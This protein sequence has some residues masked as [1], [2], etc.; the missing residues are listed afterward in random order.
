MFKRNVHKYAAV[1][2]HIA[3]PVRFFRKSVRGRLDNR[4]FA[5]VF[6]HFGKVMMNYRSFGRRLMFRICLR[7]SAER[8]F[9][10]RNKTRF[11]SGKPQKLPN[12]GHGRAFA[13][14]SRN[15]DDRK[16]FRGIIVEC[17]TDRRH[18]KPRV[19]DF[20]KCRKTEKSVLRV[21]SA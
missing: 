5:A 6:D 9:H 3:E 16:F 19:F 11:F 12:K 21:L 2:K 17:R 4:V 14:R 7:L 20:Y 18:C 13:L 1:K 15:A 10:R 8:I